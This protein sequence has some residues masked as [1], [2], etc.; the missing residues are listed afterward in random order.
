MKL[1]IVYDGQRNFLEELLA[2]WQSRFE[3]TVFAYQ[4]LNLPVAK[5]RINPPL[6]RR[7]LRRF[8]D[9]QDVVFFEWAGE[10]LVAASQL[11]PQTPLIVRLHSWELFHHA[12]RVNWTGVECVVLVSEAMRR[13]FVE[14]F[15]EQAAKAIVLPAGKSLTRFQPNLHEFN[16]N[17]AMLGNLLPIKRVY[18]MVL[19]LAEL[20][21]R[22]YKFTLHLGGKPD[23]DFNNQRYYYSLLS[24]IQKLGLQEQVVFAGWISDSASW[25]QKMDIFISNSFWEGQQNA[26]IEAMACGCYCLSHFWDGAEEILPLDFIYTT[27]S[28]LVEKIISYSNLAEE[29]KKQQQ[30][31]LRTI[32]IEK[33]N[34]TVSIQAYQK[35]IENIYNTRRVISQTTPTAIGQGR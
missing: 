27:E 31:R 29:E 22:G 8:I 17:I 28:A 21:Q 5:G 32:A 30:N 18:E 24:A 20:K 9:R 34:E 13:R 14:F 23:Q 11:V 1:G 35:L 7:A 4:E 15:P 25:L 33:Y 19:A 16:A 12:K 2:D 6:Y 10:H 3:T 26:L